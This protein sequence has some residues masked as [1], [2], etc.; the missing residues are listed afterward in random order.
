MVASAAAFGKDAPG[1][2]R[3]VATAPIRGWAESGLPHAGLTRG[4]LMTAPTVLART[5]ARS[6]NTALAAMLFAVAMT[7]IDQTIV[8]IASPN[9]QAELSMSRAGAQWVINGYI[10]ALA[11]GF[12]L[13]GRLADVLGA[14]R[15][16]IMGVV[17]FAV[18]SALCG[19]TPKGRVAEAWIITFRVLQGLSAA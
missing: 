3:P 2:A 18:S 11:A 19:F 16:V 15:V 9:I 6:R 14:R 10:L 8:A 12:A 7:F 17:G 4:T 1:R 5:T 13:G